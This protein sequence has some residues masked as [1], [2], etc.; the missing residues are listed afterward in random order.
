VNNFITGNTVDYAAEMGLDL[1]PGNTAIVTNN[2]IKGAGVWIV[3]VDYALL[4]DNTWDNCSFEV[5]QYTTSD[6]VVHKVHLTF[7]GNIVKNNSTYFNLR[8]LASGVFTNN[9]FENISAYGVFIFGNGSGNPSSEVTFNNN[10]FYNITGRAIYVGWSAVNPLTIKNNI[11]MNVSGL[12]VDNDTGTQVTVAYNDVWNSGSV[13]FNGVTATST[14]QVDPLF[15]D[16]ANSDFHLKAQ[17]GRWNGSS[18]VTDAVTSPLLDAGDPLDAYADEPNPNG[19]RINIGAYGNSDK[20]SKSVYASKAI[21]AFDFNGLSPAVIGIV[22]EGNHT[23][24]MTVPYG[25]NVAA[26]VPTL[27][28]IGASVSPDAGVVHDFTQPTIYTVTAGDGSIQNYTVTV[29]TAAY[30]AKAITKFVFNELNPAV[31]GVINEAG[32]TIALTVPQGT[33]V[34]GLVPTLAVTGVSVSP[35]AG[36]AQNYTHPI[37]YTVTAADS[38]TQPYTVTVG[39][40]PA[41]TDIE[42]LRDLAY[43]N[44]ADF[45]K[46]D[47]VT[48]VYTVP[49]ESQVCIRLYTAAGNRVKTLAN[50]QIQSAGKYSVDW[51][52]DTDGGSKAASGVY[53]VFIKIGKRV[54]KN[55]IAILR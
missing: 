5:S 34:T 18:W 38:S 55:K 2:S 41:A 17:G 29:T 14:L 4:K 19:G 20:A 24:A 45:S 3:G 39:T 35:D 32:H 6:S 26:L 15:A 42:T 10:V 8:D 52:G 7:E 36:I 25:T 21:A 47:K 28:I 11:F 49:E 12:S 31:I 37:V 33:V 9:I 16:P 1:Y 48:I 46:T 40:A 51:H 44:P 30:T 23:V 50:N 27:A 13:F 54:I 53:L 22:N 43:P